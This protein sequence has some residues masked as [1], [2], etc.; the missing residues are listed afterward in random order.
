MAAYRYRW[1][2]QIYWDALEGPGR[3]WETA[4]CALE[5]TKR[6]KEKHGTVTATGYFGRSH[7]SRIESTSKKL[8]LPRKVALKRQEFLESWDKK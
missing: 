1:T 5:A 8:P 2:D 4:L 7:H 6:G 3:V